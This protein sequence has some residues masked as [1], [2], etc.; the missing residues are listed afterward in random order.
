MISNENRTRDALVDIA[1]DINQYVYKS[2]NHPEW[3]GADVLITS[4]S[5]KTESHETFYSG[6]R[7]VVTPYASEVGWLFTRLR[8][9]F[10]GLIDGTSKIEFYGRLANAARAYQQSVNGNENAQ[11]MLKAILHEAFVILDEMEEGRFEYLSIAP[12]N[13]ILADL[14]DEAEKSGYLGPEATEEFLQ[15]MEE[16][17]SEA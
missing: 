6:P 9:A 15:R 3:K 11:D 16:K 12:G 8:D 13:M 17:H 7:T 1:K 4:N 5:S 10:D 14:I 2:C